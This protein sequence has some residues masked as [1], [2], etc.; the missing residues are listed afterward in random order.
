MYLNVFELFRWRMESYS[1]VF[2]G[3]ELVDWLMLVGLARSRS[4]GV[5]Y[6]KHLLSGRVIRHVKQLHHFYDQSFFYTFASPLT[7]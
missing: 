7:N 3:H 2:C 1:Q 4:E 6:R 5:K